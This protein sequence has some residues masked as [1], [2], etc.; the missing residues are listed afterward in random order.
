MQQR[1]HS[2]PEGGSIGTASLVAVI[3]IAAVI[4]LF[5][6]QPWDGG[7]SADAASNPP[8]STALR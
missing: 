3:V 8:A 4:A 6:W 2:A 5:I 7:A 1:T